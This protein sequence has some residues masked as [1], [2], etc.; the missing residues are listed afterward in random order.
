[1]TYEP[2]YCGPEWDRRYRNAYP[3][4][5]SVDYVYLGDK[6]AL[7][8]LYLRFRGQIGVRCERDSDN[9]FRYIFDTPLPYVDCDFGRTEPVNHVLVAFQREVVVFY[10]PFTCI[11][12]DM[13][14]V[15]DL[16]NIFRNGGCFVEYDTPGYG[17]AL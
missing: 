16:T 5:F 7:D 13:G 3:G 14:V 1:M 11:V 17:L 4:P 12:K 9:N 10:G 2:E 6:D 8:K 15:H